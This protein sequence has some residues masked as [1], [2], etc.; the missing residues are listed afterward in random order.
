MRV[1]RDST[2]E[3]G[4]DSEEGENGARR[5]AASAVDPPLPFAAP[6]APRAP[7][8]VER[9]RPAD[10]LRGASPV[11]HNTSFAPQRHVPATVGVD[12]GARVGPSPAGRSVGELGAARTGGRVVVQPD[13]L[14]AQRRRSQDTRGL[15]RRP[16]SGGS[17]DHGRRVLRRAAEGRGQIIPRTDA[18]G[19]ARIRRTPSPARRED[20]ADHGSGTGPSTKGA[21]GGD[22]G[23]GHPRRDR[24]SGPAERDDR[25][26]QD[27]LS[28]PPGRCQRTTPPHTA[29]SSGR[30]F[31]ASCTRSVRAPPRRGD[32]RAR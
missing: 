8:G 10:G 3:G 25:R 15:L 4:T 24:P 17:T 26:A 2:C 28:L 14:G 16:A 27:R 1:D 9:T 21:P 30:G 19:D 18:G 12:P 20:K 29:S 32:R 6:S 31:A 22:P 11:G 7:P 5:F 13:G 23:D